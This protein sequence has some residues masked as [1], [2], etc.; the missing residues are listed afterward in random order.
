MGWL[1]CEGARRTAP[2]QCSL[3]FAKLAVFANGRDFFRRYVQELQKL[4]MFLWCGAF[5]LG[6]PAVH[7]FI[8]EPACLH[9]C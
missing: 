9:D 6:M 3:L 5:E 2:S 7:L 8:A 4:L 1:H